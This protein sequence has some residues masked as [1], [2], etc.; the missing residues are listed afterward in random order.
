MKHSRAR[1]QAA[2]GTSATFSIARRAF[3]QRCGEIA[4]V[5]GLPLWFVERQQSEAAETTKPPTPNDR[6]G[7]G[8]IGC[9]GMGKG[10][11]ANAS[12]F[13]DILAVC[14]VDENHAAAF[15]RDFTVEGKEPPAIY[16]DFRRVME[17]R[18]IHV[19]VNATPDH[20]HTLVNLAAAQARKDIY[21][22]K[23]LTLTVDEGRQL[24]RAVREN[25]VVLQ[26][27]TQQRSSQRF[28]MACELVR[29]GRLGKLKQARV[30]LPA[31]LR[32]GPFAPS[33]V[34]AGLNWDFWQGQAPAAEYV[35]ERCH[36]NFRFWYE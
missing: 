8:I 12:A 29:N 33:P 6:P 23:P 30:W 17:R 20:W 28:R 22:E 13:G 9:G 4:A 25:G 27:G 15:A 11:A 16:R 1:H 35:K 14:D 18:D 24:V 21:G 19:I 3:L 7:I 34:P 10:D 31:G 32:G 2:R 5:T 26:T 36:A